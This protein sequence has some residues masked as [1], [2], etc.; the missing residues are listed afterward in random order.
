MYMA[1]QAEPD[2]SVLKCVVSQVRASMHMDSRKAQI[3]AAL[4]QPYSGN[5]IMLPMLTWATLT[6]NYTAIGRSGGLVISVQMVTCTGGKQLSSAGPEAV[7][8][9]SAAVTKCASTTPWLPRLL[10]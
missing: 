3:S 4:I 6:S 7:A 1:M 2:N 9:L 8:V 10:R 5:G